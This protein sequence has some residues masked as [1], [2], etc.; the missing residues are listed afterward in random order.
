MLVH[1]R[2]DRLVVQRPERRA[3]RERVAEDD[4]ARDA[5]GQRADEVVADRLVD[6]QQLAGRAA[7]PGAQEA[8]HDRGLGGGL[9]VGV[10]HHDERAVAA[11][12]EQLRLARR[13]PRDVQAGR[14]R[15]DEADAGDVRVADELVADLRARGR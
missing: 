10:V 15:A 13:A 7:L 2:R 1:L 8:G 14:G 12:L 4:V 11:H 3:L 9:D 6:E 5:L